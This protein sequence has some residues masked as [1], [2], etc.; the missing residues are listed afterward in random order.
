MPSIFCIKT[1]ECTCDVLFFEESFFK[2]DLCIEP[3]RKTAL[4]DSFGNL[5]GKNRKKRD[6]NSSTCD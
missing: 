1:G 5:F 6:F 4:R 3:V 2:S